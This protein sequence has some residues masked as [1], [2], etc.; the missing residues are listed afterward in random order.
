M[1]EWQRSREHP[2]QRDVAE[3]DHKESGNDRSYGNRRADLH[4]DWRAAAY[5]KN[6]ATKRDSSQDQKRRYVTETMV[7]SQKNEAHDA[8]HEHRGSVEI[9]QHPGKHARIHTHA[10]P[11]VS[12]ISR[13]HLR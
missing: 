7:L 6:Q 13:S 11:K 8:G 10:V 5:I 3:D 4:K 1:S 2:P 12:P 9:T